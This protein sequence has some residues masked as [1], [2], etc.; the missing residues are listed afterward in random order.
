MQS[1]WVAK[2]ALREDVAQKFLDGQNLSEED[3]QAKYGHQKPFYQADPATL[4]STD[5][6][7]PFGTIPAF[8]PAGLPKR[9]PPRARPTSRSRSTPSSRWAS[10]AEGECARHHLGS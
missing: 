9:K 5:Y 1:P 4:P 10:S 7:Y 8:G 6:G 3:Y 2:E